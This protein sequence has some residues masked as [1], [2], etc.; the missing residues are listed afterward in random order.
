MQVTTTVPYAVNENTITCVID[1]AVHTVQRSN[2]QATTILEGLARGASA[3]DLVD[4]FDQAK[5][6]KHFMH[7][8]VE[9]SGNT[10]TYKGELVHNTVSDRIL[11]FMREGGP[12]QSLVNFLERLLAN[13][14]NRSVEQ[15]YPFLEQG[16]MPITPAGTFLAYKAVRNDWTDK[17][18]GRISNRI[19]QVVKMNRNK[20]DDDPKS[21][22]SC[23]LHVGAMEYVEWFGCGVGTPGGDRVVIVEVDPANVV[24]VPYDS[25]MQKVRCCEYRVVQEFEGLLKSSYVRNADRPYAPDDEVED[26]DDITSSAWD[27]GYG[28]GR[29]EGYDE[30]HG[31]GY[32][33][34]FSAGIASA[35]DQLKDAIDDQIGG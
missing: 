2:A 9:I 23:G 20:V 1:G 8:H 13:P 31:E 3:R 24:S 26:A 11:Q 34:G 33:E 14:S 6:V 22:C 29:G 19:G 25:S 35:R 5:A 21:A 17:H 7:G 27:E 10:I 18:S 12:Y 4:M 30:G 28:E 32:D 15:L 16:N